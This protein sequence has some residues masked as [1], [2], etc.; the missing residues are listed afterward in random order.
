M[1]LAPGQ[2]H[3]TIDVVRDDWRSGEFNDRRFRGAVYERLKPN[4]LYIIIDHVAAPGTGASRTESQH[5][6]DPATVRAEVTAA[7]FVLDAESTL[8]SNKDD[9]HSANVFDAS[10]KGQ[11]DRFAHRFVRL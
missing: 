3:R 11:T 9:P 6:I 5:R 2:N 8:L 4:G 1:R 7:G 10:I